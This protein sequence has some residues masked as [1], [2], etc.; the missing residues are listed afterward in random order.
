MSGQIIH[1]RAWKGRK[2]HPACRKVGNDPKGGTTATDPAKVT[3]HM[4]KAKMAAMVSA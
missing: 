1:A 3:C 4:C 2:A